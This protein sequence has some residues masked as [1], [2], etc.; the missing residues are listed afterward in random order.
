MESPSSK[1]YQKSTELLIPQLAFSRLV[2]EVTQESTKDKRL[3]KRA[4][5][6][7]QEAAEAYLVAL[8]EDNKLC[9]THAKR[10]TI[11]PKDMRLA[12]CLSK[13]YI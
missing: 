8:F 5:L 1:K 6:A 10:V 12:V 7:L 2:C 4:V 3:A 11:T 9:A 13:R